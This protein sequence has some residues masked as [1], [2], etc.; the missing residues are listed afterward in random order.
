[1]KNTIKAILLILISVLIFS[2]ISTFTPF[3]E[4][5]IVVSLSQ[6]YCGVD[7]FKYFVRFYSAS[8]YLLMFP[9]ILIVFFGITVFV[10]SYLLKLNLTLREV[11]QNVLGSYFPYLVLFWV[12]VIS[13]GMLVCAGVLLI[14][15]FSKKIYIVKSILIFVVSL[16]LFTTGLSFIL[17]SFYLSSNY[18]LAEPVKT[19]DLYLVGYTD[20]GKCCIQ[21]SSHNY[22]ITYDIPLVKSVEIH[23]PFSFYET[24]PIGEVVFFSYLNLQVIGGY[25]LPNKVVAGLNLKKSFPLKFSDIDNPPVKLYYI[26]YISGKKTCILY[27]P[28]WKEQLFGYHDGDITPLMM[29]FEE[30]TPSMFLMSARSKKIN[31]INLFRKGLSNLKQGLPADNIVTPFLHG[32]RIFYSKDDRQVMKYINP[33]EYINSEVKIPVK[34]LTVVPWHTFEPYDSKIK[35][36]K[37]SPELIPLTKDIFNK[38]SKEHPAFVEYN[39]TDPFREPYTY[40]NYP[41][42]TPFWPTKVNEEFIKKNNCIFLRPLWAG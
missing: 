5:S 23:Q 4:R 14:Y 2:T 36:M 21:S 8:I 26:G 28:V 11:M 13:W 16:I 35:A 30:N 40:I 18:Q 20:D 7:I 12:P 32:F 22:N 41:Q 6:T 33:I 19:G 25:L 9:L 39:L 15:K 24:M 42:V 17:F 37:T 27:F 38:L 1:M 31:K 10:A 3:S 34:V 29:C